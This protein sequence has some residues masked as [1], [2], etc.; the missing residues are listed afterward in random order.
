MQTADMTQSLSTVLEAALLA[1]AAD[2]R[3]VR[4]VS[5]TLDYGARGPGDMTVEARVDRATRSLVFA[6]GEARLADGRT[7]A[8]AC[9]VFRVAGS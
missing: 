1:A 8:T 2:G 5:L 4:P 9:G 6:S 3:D 7:A